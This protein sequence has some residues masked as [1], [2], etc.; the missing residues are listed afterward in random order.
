[1]ALHVA[2]N[3]SLQAAP[4]RQQIRELIEDHERRRRDLLWQGQKLVER[5]KPRRVC[6]I[7]SPTHAHGP[8]A[9]L[10]LERVEPG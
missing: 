7:G 2:A 4:D 5:L 6:P 8:G 3:Q 10:D 9:H 1:V